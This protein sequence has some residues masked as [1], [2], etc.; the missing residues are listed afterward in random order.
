MCGNFGLLMLGKEE[1]DKGPVANEFEK[2]KKPQDAMDVSLHQT[3]HE[4][5]KL[6]GLRVVGDAQWTHNISTSGKYNVIESTSSHAGSAPLLDPLFILEA[7]TAATEVRGGQ[8]GGISSIEYTQ[9]KAAGGSSG[10]DAKFSSGGE[11]IPNMFRVR[12]VA[13][14][15]Y[16]LAKDLAQKFLDRFGRQPD[17]SLAVT[18]V[19][20]TRFATSSI[21]VE[22]ELHPHEWVPIRAETVWRMSSSGK[23]EQS[24]LAYCLHLTHNG[25]FDAMDMYSTTI[26]NGEIGLWLER[27]LH[28]EN[29][30]R[31]D[32]PKLAG[33][34]DVMRVAGRWGP[35]VRLGYLRLLKSVN[36]VCDGEQLTKEAPNT[37]PTWEYFQDWAYEV[38][39]P[40]WNMHKNNI[41]KAYT[42]E[43]TGPEKK[44]TEYY[45][46]TA[47]ENQFA[48]AVL[49][50]IDNFKERFEILKVWTKKEKIA[51]VRLT[52]RGFLRNDLYTA[53]TEILSRA[54][55]SFGIQSHCTM[56]VG[57][58]VIASKGQPMSVSFGP[59]LSVC[60]YGS[61]A[62]AIAV[63]VDIEG[64]WLP[65]R[66]D[67]DSKGEIMRLGRPRDLI[68]GKY[69]HF[70]QHH[71][72]HEETKEDHL[73]KK[74]IYEGPA[75][76]KNIAKI[77]RTKGFGQRA[78]LR[79][80]GGIE[81]LS[82]SLVSDCE[83]MGQE[84]VDRSVTINSAP[85][86]YDPKADLVA[87]DLAMIPGILDAIDRAW[88]S[89]SSVEFIVAEEFCRF[90]IAC[91][92][93]RI[94]THTDSTDLIIGTL[95]CHHHY[96]FISHSSISIRWC[97]GLFM[98]C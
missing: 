46:D 33:M 34:M 6:H 43:Q 23:F 47:G 14:K 16:P 61:E 80:R 75:S 93:H 31:G 90:M 84:L 95:S 9:S 70:T 5:S 64:G 37:F 44:G 98:G 13:R 27:V 58:V 56:E 65:E 15:R 71:G 25:D 1:S 76:R 19:G 97:R 20:H 69:N 73:S 94:D 85:I 81:I 42:G 48:E 35:A 3:L 17:S 30:T 63:P 36:D 39:E 52:I 54:E 38:F 32:S 22:S 74:P 2:T 72:S 18:F 89:T 7:Q 55:G 59:D 82:Y 4:V 66:I 45:I 29:N 88:G 50:K 41:I 62:E 86:P 40:D 8:A 60:L 91:M 21:N 10:Y 77:Q 57:V 28:C 12:A 79:M 49:S 51:F 92:K 11:S 78:G 24:E 87:A 26:V 53:L 96:P 83:A 68:E 67:L